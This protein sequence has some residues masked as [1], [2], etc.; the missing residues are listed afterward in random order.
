VSARSAIAP[1]SL[2]DQLNV[3]ELAELLALSPFEAVLLCFVV[4]DLAARQGTT[5]L[6]LVE[7]ARD[8][9]GHRK[10]LVQMVRACAPAQ[11]ACLADALALVRAESKGAQP[12]PRS[13]HSPHG[14]NA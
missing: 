13:F 5:A 12:S 4:S 14:G 11:R 9:A 3:G 1:L 8:C 7:H 6:S 2:L 10:A